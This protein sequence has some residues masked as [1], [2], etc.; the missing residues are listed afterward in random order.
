MAKKTKDTPFEVTI[1][2]DTDIEESKPETQV[3]TLV[4]TDVS[5][6]SNVIKTGDTIRVDW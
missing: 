4:E 2:L 3:E 5:K 6:A 1:D